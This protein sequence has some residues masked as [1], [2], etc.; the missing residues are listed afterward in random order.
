MRESTHLLLSSRVFFLT[1]THFPY[2]IIFFSIFDWSL[3]TLAASQSHALFVSKNIFKSNRCHSSIVW[4]FYVPEVSPKEDLTILNLREFLVQK[5]FFVAFIQRKLIFGANLLY[6][7]GKSY[8]SFK[9]GVFCDASVT[10]ELFEQI[11]LTEIGFYDRRIFLLFLPLLFICCITKRIV[12]Y[13]LMRKF[14][15]LTRGG[16]CIPTTRVKATI[17]A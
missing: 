12:D 7:Q 11:K 6:L 13:V 3:H 17:S 2:S 9:I 5:T 1:M 10:Y 8:L 15:I 14:V 16:V 4:M